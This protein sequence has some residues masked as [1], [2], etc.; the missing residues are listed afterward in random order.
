MQQLMGEDL[1]EEGPA[2]VQKRRQVRLGFLA[3]GAEALHEVEGWRVRS[4]CLY[5]CVA[6]VKVRNLDLVEGEVLLTGLAHQ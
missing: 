6:E 2:A 3:V 1:G 5:L 4:S